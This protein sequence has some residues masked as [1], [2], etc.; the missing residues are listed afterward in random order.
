M[1]GDP[2]AKRLLEDKMSRTYLVLQRLVPAMA[3]AV[4]NSGKKTFFGS[5]KGR[6]HYERFRSLLMPLFS[7]MWQDDLIDS[8]APYDEILKVTQNA[9][10]LF[11]R[12]HPNWP[13][14][15]AF[16]QFIFFENEAKALLLIEGLHLAA[17]NSVK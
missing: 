10:L 6:L 4:N 7:A 8:K 9:I 3:D 15:Y 17:M 14:A 2:E 16:G 11:Q 5:D 12:A 13:E 1:A